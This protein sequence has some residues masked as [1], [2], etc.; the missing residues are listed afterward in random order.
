VQGRGPR[1]GDIAGPVTG[2]A[3]RQVR[4][5]GGGVG[6]VGNERNLIAC[7]SPVPFLSH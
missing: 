5:L 6:F 7:P 2:K 1:H 3:R 4:R